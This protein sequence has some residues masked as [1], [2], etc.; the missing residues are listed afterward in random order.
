MKLRF[1]P[2]VYAWLVSL[3]AAPVPVA[4]PSAI[5]EHVAACVRCRGGVL[6]LAGELL[7]APFAPAA[8]DCDQCQDDLAAFIDLERDEGTLTALHEYAHV[9]WHL[10]QCADCVEVYR[11][12]LTLQQAEAEQRLPPLPLLSLVPPPLH[13]VLPRTHIL[14]ALA[15][16][17][18][19]GQSGCVDD[20]LLF[21]GPVAGCV[22]TV[23]LRQQDE[24]WYLWGH[25]LP[26]PTGSLVVK[27]GAECHLAPFDTYG[28][29]LVGPLPT[30]LLLDGTG[31]PLE[32]GV[33]G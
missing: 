26:P 10:W 16:Q 23:S 13:V 7:G 30:S 17:R 9:W 29:T 20:L 31:P 6:L 8:G 14:E 12:V 15:A 28:Q 24:C 21:E 33:W 22:L 25:G 3:D 5:T 18:V 27:M 32:L 4:P 19:V 11:M 1:C 2:E